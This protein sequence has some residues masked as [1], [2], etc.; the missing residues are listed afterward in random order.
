[1]GPADVCL[2][3]IHINM[4]KLSEVSAVFLNDASSTAAAMVDDASST[5]A[6]M[7]DLPKPTRAQERMI[8]KSL[9]LMLWKQ[10]VSG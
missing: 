2:P 6:A 5:V 3:T 7:V 1:M 8:I 4:G 9:T 10:A